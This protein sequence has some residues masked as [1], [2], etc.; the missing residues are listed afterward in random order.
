ME[1]LTFW[2]ISQLHGTKDFASDNLEITK[3]IFTQS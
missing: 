1:S 2:E 3:I